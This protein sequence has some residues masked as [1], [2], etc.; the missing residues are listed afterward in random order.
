MEVEFRIEEQ[1]FGMKRVLGLLLFGVVGV[2]TVYGAIPINAIKLEKIKPAET[3]YT[4]KV[5]AIEK[6]VFS[7]DVEGKVRDVK[8]TGEYVF[9]GIHDKK[10]KSV[11]R[12]GTVVAEYDRTRQEFALQEA[13]MSRRIAEAEFRQ[14]M[15]NYHRY[16]GLVAKKA[17]SPKDYLEV[18]TKYMN[19]KLNLRKA[20][21][22]LARAKYNL[23]ACKIVAPFSGIVS[24][25]F[26]SEGAHV[27]KGDNIVELTKMTPLLIK[28]PFP[29]EI[30]SAFREGTQVEIYPVNGGKP[31]KAWCRTKLKEPFLYAYIDNTIVGQSDATESSKYKKV[32]E[33]FPVKTISDSGGI[34]KEL[35][36][37]RNT[38]GKGKNPLAVPVDAIKKDNKG[39]YVLKAEQSGELKNLSLFKISRVDILPGGIERDFNMGS[40]RDVKIISLENSG[41]LKADDTLMLLGDK[42]IK[43][44]DTAVFENIRWKFAP[45][46]L[47]KVSIPELNEAGYYVP[48]KAIIHQA[49]N[50]NYVY[51]LKNNK[52]EL[53]KVDI[54]GRS[55]G[56]NRISGHGIED[57]TEIVYMDKP[58]LFKKLYNTAD[59]KVESVI[60][61]YKRLLHKRADQLLLGISEIEKTYY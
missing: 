6:G 35:G 27:G 32:Y 29:E 13:K 56:Y 42:N 28:I 49:D 52:A 58:N 45:G 15:A 11:I 5:E 18:S 23:D 53:V 43:D 61:P 38:L 36:N 55:S 51:L 12:K 34:L 50:D 24:K 59:V 20:D 30:V 14:A 39:Y 16:K 21:T 47:V 10:N 17:V 25:V 1:R 60:T 3:F 54:T 37:V 44:G 2:G 22:S 7:F 57:G 46:Q 40:Q 26:I 4:G 48:P 31:V 19:A 9:E 8:K 33:I 41:S